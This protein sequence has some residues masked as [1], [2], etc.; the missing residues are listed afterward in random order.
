MQ[1]LAM[2]DAIL[3]PEWVNRYY[4]FNAHWGTGK[5]MASMRDGSGDELFVLFTSTGAI[6]KGFAHEAPM[7]PYAEDPPTIWPGVL[8]SVPVAFADFLNEP[9]F[10]LLDTTFCIWRT[11]NDVAWQRGNIEF[12][13]G[14]DPDGSADLLEMLTGD[15]QTYQT[16]A[17]YYYGCPVSLSAVTSIYKHCPL[18]RE[19]V[20]E[21]NPNVLIQALA[22]DIQDI[23]YTSEKTR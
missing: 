14:K 6:L 9:A 13:E 23:E 16:W 17:E 18:T 20:I 1:S 15:P 10:S 12:P 5:A 7:S 3:S 2:L 11:Y 21:L 8:D 22:Q 4:S 19:L